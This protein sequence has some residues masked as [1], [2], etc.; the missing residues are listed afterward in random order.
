MK[1]KVKRRVAV[2]V[3]TAK[4]ISAPLASRIER[5]N[6]L[7]TALSTI[8][9]IGAVGL[10][11][12]GGRLAVKLI[13]NPAS[14]GWIGQILPSWSEFASAKPQTWSE[15][16]AEIT[17]AKLQLGA[18]IHFSTYPGMTQSQ[19]GFHHLLLPILRP[20]KH[21]V[22]ACSQI[23]ELRIYRPKAT[24]L[25]PTYELIDR[26]AVTGPAE[27]EAVAPLSSALTSSTRTLPLTRIGF[28]EAHAP[29][30]LWLQLSGEWQR[31]SRLLYGQVVQYDPNRAQVLLL[32]AWSSPADKLPQWQQVTGSATPEL[33]VDQ[34]VG[35]EPQFQVFQLKALRSLIQPITLEPI[36]LT[37]AAIHE[38]SYENGLLLARKGLW[39]MAL[40]KLKA[41]KRP[42]WPAQAQAQLDLIALHAKVTQAQAEQDW[43]SPTQQVLAQVI[44]GRWSQ[45]LA[46]LKSA[47]RSGY[48]IRTLLATNSDKLWERVEA[49]L[50]LNAKQADLQAWATLILSVRQNQQQALSWLRKQPSVTPELTQSMQIILAKLN[51][52]TAPAAL[53]SPTPTAAEPLGLVALVQPLPAIQM[54]DWSPLVKT[55]AMTAAPPAQQRW[56]QVEVQNLQ[57]GQQWQKPVAPAASKL[58]A[59][60]AFTAANPLQL[61]V[62]QGVA[63]LQTIPLTI[64]AT[65]LTAGRLSL[66][67]LGAALPATAQPTTLVAVTPNV[68]WLQPQGSITLSAL[69]QQPDWKPLLPQLWQAL[70]A[71]RLVPDSEADPLATIGAW[72]VQYLELTGDQTPEAVLTLE[73]D[74]G[75][76]RTVIFSDQKLLYS[77]LQQPDQSLVGLAAAANRAMLLVKRGQALEV[78]QWL[79]QAQQFE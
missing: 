66:L 65:Q 23:V 56:Y 30:G 75:D 45:S 34:S 17:Q 26:M 4:P 48:D 42:H 58:I 61:V 70:V 64:K 69:M 15:I 67:G 38:R 40:A 59:A 52:E 71:A 12:G 10:V 78:K 77:D 50:R 68:T 79:E 28:L 9:L 27:L 53:P 39:S 33:V 46:A 49:A 62:W 1:P 14:V 37:A 16:E 32:Q 22:P 73:P 20:I 7:G 8:L 25:K 6:R 2:R 44:D 3:W 41:L 24:K 76:L 19:P 60:Q 35:L 5:P 43:A 57:V 29:A 21:C 36:S 63:Q 54:Q 72:S 13:V 51:P 47:S 18:P 55:V 11:A 74:A 31:G